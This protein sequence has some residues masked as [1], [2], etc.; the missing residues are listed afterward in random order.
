MTHPDPQPPIPRPVLALHGLAALMVI[1][2]GAVYLGRSSI[3]PYHLDAIETTWSDLDPRHRALYLAFFK[4]VGAGYLSAGLALLIIVLGPMRCGARW[5]L[6]AAPLVT[7]AGMVPLVGIILF[8]RAHTPADPPMAYPVLILVLSA[9]AVG[10][11]LHARARHPT[12]D[13][14]S[15]HSGALTP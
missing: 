15:G 12:E 10:L 6:W 9:I 3:M 2:L 7:F 13:T 14:S 5:T 1:V 4:G 11:S 8:V